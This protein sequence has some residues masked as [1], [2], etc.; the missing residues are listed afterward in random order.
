M[1]ALAASIAVKSNL[2]DC[3]ENFLGAVGLRSDGV[4]VTARNVSDKKPAPNHHA[5]ARLSRKMTPHS[6]VWVARVR[7]NGEWAL[8]RPCRGCQMR[9]QSVGVSKVV[10]TIGPGEW[11]VI[12]F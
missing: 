1:L 12:N 6:T 3:R 5:E 10:Y 8:A 9:M 4:I 11:G 7:N 2:G